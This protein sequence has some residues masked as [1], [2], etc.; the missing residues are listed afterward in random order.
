MTTRINPNGLNRLMGQIERDVEAATFRVYQKT[1]D[2]C[3]KRTGATARSFEWEVN[4]LGDK[5]V[6]RV[7]S[8]DPV[9]GYIEH[10]SRAVRN[11]PK[12]M[13]PLPAPY[14]RFIRSRKAIPPRPFMARALRLA[15]PYP[16]RD[17]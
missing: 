11:N 10:G 14:P 12:P 4:R 16:V 5:F 1:V 17:R 3:P 2:L 6:G 8:D 7:W 15:A 9:V 13:G